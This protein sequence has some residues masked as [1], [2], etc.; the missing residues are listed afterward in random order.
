MA[1]TLVIDKIKGGSAGVALT[2]P[3]VDGSANQ[4]IKT[5]G[6]GALGWASQVTTSLGINANILKFTDED[7]IETNIDLSLYLDDTNLARL[8]TGTLD[9]GTGIA[10]FTR[11]DSTTF[12]VDFSALLD[13]TQ[14]TVNNTLTSTSTSDAL[15][16]A[17]GKALQDNKVDN[18]R[19][20]TDV[21]SGALFTDTNTT[22]SVG[23]GGLTEKNFTDADHSKLDGIAA[24]ANNYTHPASHTIAE[25]TGLQTALD[26]K[27]PL[28]GGTLTGNLSL[29]DNNKA[30]FGAS[31]DLQIYHDATNSYIDSN[32]GR[33][34]VT[35]AETI[36]LT[37]SNNTE[38]YARFNEDGSV[39]LYYDNTLKLSTTSSGIDVTGTVT[40]DGLTVDGNSQLKSIKET[41]VNDTATIDLNAGTVF[42]FTATT[43]VTMPTPEVGRS[44]TVVSEAG[45]LSWTGATI[46]WSAGAVPSG[47]GIV[48]YSFIATNT[49]EW[50]GMEAG[51]A[52]A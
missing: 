5:D 31:D 42:N 50:L 51:S 9:G 2:L 40:A 12:T 52:F 20:L 46:K 44:I 41:Q 16:A 26:G 35:A 4:Y 17:Q 28:A 49:T 29:G 38:N 37:N 47:T 10:T 43:T 24:S 25:V 21:P 7:G 22:Y 48:I 23:D 6:S 15:S 33:L 45:Q 30:K 13:D 1:S 34:Y 14:V 18:S 8:T 32:T 11:D 19:V 39:Q 36:R 3:T 27:L